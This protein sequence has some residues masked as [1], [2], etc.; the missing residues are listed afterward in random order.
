MHA[1]W[2]RTG[3]AQLVLDEDVQVRVLSITEEG[4]GVAVRS[5]ATA[6]VGTRPAGRPGEAHLWAEVLQIRDGGMPSLPGRFEECILRCLRA[7]VVVGRVDLVTL[8]VDVLGVITVEG[9]ELLEKRTWL[10]SPAATTDS[11]DTVPVASTHL[12]G[13]GQKFLVRPTGLLPVVNVN[14]PLTVVAALVSV[15]KHSG[16]VMG[17]LCLSSLTA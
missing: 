12:L 4:V 5:V 10:I 6:A 1:Y 17:M 11:Q 13:K 14:Q 9:L 3:H 8:A 7:E 15:Q 2:N 16:V